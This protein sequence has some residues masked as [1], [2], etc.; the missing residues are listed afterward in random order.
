[1]L[2]NHVFSV[3]AKCIPG[4]AIYNLCCRKSFVLFRKTY[5]ISQKAKN[6]FWCFS[7][8]SKDTKI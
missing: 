4:K 5:A 7:L 1:M 8:S 6:F 2:N 3:S